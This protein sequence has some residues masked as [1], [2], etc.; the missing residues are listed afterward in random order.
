[1]A[2]I[3]NM[4]PRATARL[5]A[6]VRHP[7]RRTSPPD[8]AARGTVDSQAVV[9]AAAYTPSM[10]STGSVPSSASSR[11]IALV[12]AF[13]LATKMSVSAARPL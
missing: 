2:R 7:L 1:M 12:Y 4:R 11:F 10:V 9:S 5:E 13:A 8:A 6:A 3:A